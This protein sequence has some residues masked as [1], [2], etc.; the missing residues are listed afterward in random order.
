MINKIKIAIVGLGHIGK[1]HTDAILLNAS[2]KL[3]AICDKN[4]AF[5]SIMVKGAVFYESHLKMLE[6]GGFDVVVVATPN[7]THATIAKDIL[8]YGYNLILEKP[9]ANS[10]EELK[11]LESLATHK[12]KHI[13]YAFHAAYA[14]EV[15]WFCEYYK[16]KKE[17]LGDIKAFYSY[18][19]DPYF[20]QD[21]VI[22]YA[23]GL[24]YPWKDSG[25]NALSVLICFMNLN[26]LTLSST[27]ASRCKAQETSHL[28]KYELQNGYFGIVNTAWNQDR[29]FKCT[30]L[31]FECG[32]K[33]EINHTEQKVVM[34]DSTDGNKEL[35][36]FD[37]ERLLNHYKN[38]FADYITQRKNNTFNFDISLAI[39]QKLYEEKGKT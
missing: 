12:N 5:Q 19:Y 20:T 32:V 2:Y 25:V 36:S 24:E 35:K 13:Y 23:L 31:Y 26:H 29:N 34:V 14:S 8:N 4:S 16:K 7:N 1:I 6:K 21:R 3:V 18:F 30:E 22:D 17:S 9:A 15:L 28:R 38:I 10:I 39:H 37:G 11:E 33:I 27:R